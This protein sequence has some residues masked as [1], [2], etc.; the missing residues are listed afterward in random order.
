M[1]ITIDFTELKVL[2]SFAQRRYIVL[3]V[4]SLKIR[5]LQKRLCSNGIFSPKLNWKNSMERRHP[6][7]WSK[8]QLGTNGS[9]ITRHCFAWK[10]LSHC[11]RI[12][13]IVLLRASI[14]LSKSSRFSCRWG[15]NCFSKDTRQWSTC[16]QQ[17]WNLH[18]VFLPPLY[19]VRLGKVT[20]S[21]DSIFSMYGN[22]SGFDYS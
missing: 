20:L 16:L 7:L 5:Y 19:G 4:T 9:Y 17:S 15:K 13:E 21:M 1:F 22:C 6:S 3:P 2:F 11:N 10:T 14:V 18:I 8:L 12:D